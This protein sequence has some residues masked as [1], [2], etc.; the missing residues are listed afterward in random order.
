MA[1]LTAV[2]AHAIEPRHGDAETHF[3][4]RIRPVLM[5]QCFNCH[6]GDKTSNHLRVDSRTA[7]LKGGDAGAS[8]VPGDPDK[9]LLIKAIRYTD[10]D[11]QM[12][13]KH[14]LPRGVVDDFVTWV[15]SGAPWP[16]AKDGHD[17]FTVKKALGL[18]A[19]ETR[20]RAVGS[21]RL[22]APAA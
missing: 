10:D 15:R 11:L 21:F 8:L 20:G 17:A 1:L 14:Q 2:A 12:P 13:P 7:L 4:T 22:V 3:E 6:G 19:R 18:R 9:S 5:N 16:I